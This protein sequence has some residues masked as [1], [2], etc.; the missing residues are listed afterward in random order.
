MANN[1]LSI[2]PSKSFLYDRVIEVTL[3]PDAG[4][5]LK[6]GKRKG[7]IKPDITFSVSELPQNKCYQV[8][9]N[10]RNLGLTND[11]LRTYTQM[12]IT[13]GYQ[14]LSTLQPGELQTFSCSIFTA[15]CESP[16]PDGLTVITGIVVGDIIGVMETKQLTLEIRSST[17]W[18][19]VTETIGKALGYNINFY[20]SEDFMYE[21]PTKDKTSFKTSFDN[22]WQAIMWLQLQL[23]EYGKN[24]LH[25]PVFLTVWHKTISVFALSEALNLTTLTHYGIVNLSAI[26]RASFAGPKLDVI[27]PWIPSLIPGGIFYMPPTYYQA[28]ALP[29]IMPKTTYTNKR[30]LY[31]VIVMDVKFGTRTGNQ[32]HIIAVPVQ[33][34]IPKDGKLD[35]TEDSVV[36]SKMG[37]LRQTYLTKHKDQVI[38]L[39]LGEGQKAE[40]L[41]QELNN[42]WNAATDGNFQGILGV[43]SSIVDQGWSERAADLVYYQGV[44]KYSRAR[45]VERY[46]I[47]NYRKICKEVDT[48]I[49]ATQDPIRIPMVFFWPLL[50]LGTYWKYKVNGNKGPIGT[51]LKDSG[52]DDSLK[53]DLYNP[54]K[55]NAH[56]KI[57]VP[58]ID[59]AMA[60]SGQLDIFGDALVAFGKYYTTKYKGAKDKESHDK[61]VFGQNTYKAGICLGGWKE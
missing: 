31:Y 57:W 30:D 54:D 14:G 6:I 3:E 29:N 56:I 22:G 1:T 34:V 32:M 45:L 16:N 2:S 42:Y 24:V 46:G 11:Q 5:P 26:T 35:Y 60:D 27:A 39:V 9:L 53:V 47:N 25:S 20:L 37:D 18:K 8:E 44:W 28:S 61:Y 55:I 19:T 58:A 17:S 13:A 33:Y 36:M 12:K 43:E 48:G 50:P 23:F 40:E 7:G 4:I 21:L 59:I 15:Y 51:R 52:T 38:E 41:A 49:D 10:I